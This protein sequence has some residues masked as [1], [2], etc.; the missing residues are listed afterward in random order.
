LE[1]HPELEEHPASDHA[2]KVQLIDKMEKAIG[3]RHAYINWDLVHNMMTAQ[4][5]VAQVVATLHPP[6]VA[7]NAGVETDDDANKT[8]EDKSDK[9]KSAK[10]TAASF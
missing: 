1:V 2:R 6:K 10:K 8:K 5:G 9:K 4:T 7:E 3:N